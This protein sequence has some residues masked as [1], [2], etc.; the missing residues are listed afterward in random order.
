M[1]WESSEEFSKQIDGLPARIQTRFEWDQELSQL[2]A[3]RVKLEYNSSRGW[4]PIAVIPHSNPARDDL[5]DV[6]S[7]GI[8][9]YLYRDGQI[10]YMRREVD[11]DR[12]QG[13]DPSI[14]M[15]LSV[16]R[17]NEIAPRLIQTYNQ[18]E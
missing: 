11:S 13:T 8:C 10:K 14:C 4:Q 7:Q 16:R 2:D 17:L 1:S 6:L 9:V 15:I 18:W 5:P 12:I 3:F